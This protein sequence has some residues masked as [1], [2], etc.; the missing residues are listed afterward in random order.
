MESVQI[1]NINLG[2]VEFLLTGLFCFRL[3]AFSM[4]AVR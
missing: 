1:S 3:A 4:A 2:D